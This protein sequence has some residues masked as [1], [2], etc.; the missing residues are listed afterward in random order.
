MPKQIHV[1]KI[2][3]VYTPSPFYNSS[4]VFHVPQLPDSSLTISIPNSCKSKSNLPSLL[5][6]FLLLTGLV[7]EFRKN[8]QLRKLWFVFYFLLLS[9]ILDVLVMCT[10]NFHGGVTLKKHT[11]YFFALFCN[12]ITWHSLRRKKNKLTNVLRMFGKLC[13]AVHSKRTSVTVLI[14]L[15]FPFIFS[16]I[17]TLLCNKTLASLFYAYGYELKSLT[18]QVCV[19][20]IKTFLM[21]LAQTTYPSLVAVLFCNLCM[22]W[23][24]YYNC[25]TRKV[26]EYSS[27]KF[28]PLE[29]IHILKQKAR[30]D[31]IL[32]KLQDIFSLPSFFVILSNFLTCCSTLGIIL[33][34]HPS[35]ITLVTAVFV[36][37]PNLVSLVVVLW[38][39]GG[40]PVEQDKLKDAFFKRAHYR[41]LLVL[42]SEEQQFKREILDKPDFVLNGCNIFSYTRNSF[43][44]LIGTLLTYALLIYQN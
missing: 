20:S 44:T 40:L 3:T 10:I 25:L 12:L 31:D 6:S 16:T 17:I 29:Q 33:T 42:S 19:I 34:G 35:K 41:Y 13:P 21:F 7:E 36:G 22:R 14:I 37:I 27:E 4:S 5:F 24:S 38:V 32:E 30:V 39:A 8:L 43:L 15:S 28:G 9:Q 23:S 11:T 18:L 1:K 2:E 26:L